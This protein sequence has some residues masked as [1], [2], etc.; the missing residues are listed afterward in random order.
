[1]TGILTFKT[2]LP[3]GIVSYFLVIVLLKMCYN[4]RNFGQDI[5]GEIMRDHSYKKTACDIQSLV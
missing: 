2:R 1:M 4:R 3:A 5:L